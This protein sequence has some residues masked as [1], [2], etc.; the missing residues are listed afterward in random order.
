M[1]KTL[2]EELERIHSITYGKNVINE[3]LLDTILTKIGVKK[4]VDDPKKADL[5]SDDVSEYYKTLEKA[6]ESGI[7]QQERGSMS[8]QKEV[9]SMQIGLI[10]LGYELPK[11]GVD[12]LFGP[13]TAAAVS[14]F[15]KEKVDEDEKSVN[16]SVKLVSQGGGLIGRPGQGT[17]SASG[18][19]S[20][21]AWDVKGPEGAD[22]FSLTNGVI[23]KLKKDPNK[24]IVQSGVKK[25]YG[26]Q[27]SVKSSDGKPDVFYTHIVSNLEVGDSVKEGDVIGKIMLVPGMP[28]HVHVGLSSGN[29]SDLAVGLDSAVGGTSQGGTNTN[30]VKATPEMLNK[31]IELLKDRGITSEEIKQYLDVASSTGGGFAD[32]DLKTDEGFETYSKIAQKFIES[33]SDNPLNITGTMLANGARRAQ[34]RYGNYV[35]VELALAQLALEGG[36]GNSDLNSRPIKTRNPFNVGNV[37]SGKDTYQSDVQSGINAYY[38][39]I[40]KNYIGKGKTANDL[41]SNFVNKSGNRYA[42]AKDYE[43]KLSSLVNQANRMSINLT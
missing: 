33:K 28:T 27:V 2:T 23:E 37:D 9:E 16:E 39:L 4:S 43:S 41:M 17:H 1:K 30:M 22:V 42:S 11:Y 12:G 5:V 26:D 6:A 15:I 20:N 13:E 8:F 34:D 3:G 7:T 38:D 32:I 21:N 24:G 25:I 18:W 31:L 36:I 14:K 19:E 40:A 10:L 29:L 35:P